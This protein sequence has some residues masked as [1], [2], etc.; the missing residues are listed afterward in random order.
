MPTDRFPVGASHI[1]MFARSVGDDNPIYHDAEYEAR[2]ET[3]HIIAPLT[4]PQ[5][6]A[7]LAPDILATD[8]DME[9]NDDS[10]LDLL[11]LCHY[12]RRVG[13]ACG[14][15]HPIGQKSGPLV[16]YQKFEYAKGSWLLLSRI[17]Q[18]QYLDI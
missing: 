5:A 1:M 12:D 11:H 2:T 9:F 14:R 3:G 18:L 15:T 16:W 10:V 6:Q 8:A 17:I 13:G 7:Q 4:F